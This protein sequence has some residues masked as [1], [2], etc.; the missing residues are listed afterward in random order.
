MRQR[1]SEDYAA[2]LGE[3]TVVLPTVQRR[4]VVPTEPPENHGPAN[5]PPGNHGPRPHRPV[6][7][8]DPQQQDPVAGRGR[9]AT[10]PARTSPTTRRRWPVPAGASPP[11]GPAT[12]PS[13]GTGRP[14]ATARSRPGRR[15]GR[16][17]GSGAGMRRCRGASAGSGSTCARW[18]LCDLLA[19]VGRGRGDL[20]AAL[21]R[22]GDHLQPLVRAAVG[23]AA[24]GA[25]AGAGG[26]PGVRAP[27]PVRRHGRVPA[28]VPGRG[29][30]D[31]RGGRRLVR[32]RSGSC[33]VL[34]P[35]RAA[36][37]DRLGRGPA[38]R[39]AQ[40]AA[41]RPGPRGAACA[42]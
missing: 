20:R 22:R 12:G 15:A 9:P 1:L 40:A 34:R 16:S 25:A 32:A 36:D 24:G 6:A 37:R 4:D 11:T 23:A 13:S 41:L 8:P 29:R 17:S 35:G 21:R 10:T 28:G 2:A 33:P 42:G 27:L 5:H 3:P 31:R 38:V 19:G 18:S 26:E 30:P 39:A 14:S 7:V